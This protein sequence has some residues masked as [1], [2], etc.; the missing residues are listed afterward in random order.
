MWAGVGFALGAGM[1]WGLVFV[2]PVLLP[3]YPGVLQ[4][5]GRYV[6]F[7]LIALPLGWL[8][9]AALARFTRADWFA[10]LK[11]AAVGNL[12]YYTCLASAIQRAGGPVVT[13]MIGTL[14]VI[15]A[16]CSNLR[17]HRRDGRLP[18]RR[19]LPSLFAI[20]LG[21]E[22]I[23]H[24][25]TVGTSSMLQFGNDFRVDRV[26]FTT[27][28]PLVLS[29]WFQ[30]QVFRHMDVRITTQV[31]LMDFLGDDIQADSSQW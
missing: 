3:E 20:G 6:A 18:W 16:I 23:V 22:L 10:A 30:V 14:P 13:M 11:L 7:G 25:L 17:D 27:A 26:E 9:R 28:T 29:S 21:C 1:L 31:S 24:P 5:V 8:D 12:L 19:L 2:G 15:I 4:S